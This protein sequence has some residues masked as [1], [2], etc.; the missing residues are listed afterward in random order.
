[1]PLSV[2]NPDQFNVDHFRGEVWKEFDV[3]QLPGFSSRTE[4]KA[5]KKKR[6][7][8]NSTVDKF[9]EL[10]NSENPPATE[11][12]MLAELTP[13]MTWLLSWFIRQLVIQVLK[14]CWSRW[15]S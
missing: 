9:V 2:F 1:M 10:M 15:N 5:R 7:R 11:A 12:E 8:V 6:E 13:V 3:D 14:F 4:P